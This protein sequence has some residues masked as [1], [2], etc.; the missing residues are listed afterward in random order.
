MYAY[1]IARRSED[2]GLLRPGT[3]VSME[4]KGFDMVDGRCPDEVC[5]ILG[6]VGG[7]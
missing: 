1:F 7:E 3:L 2:V 5:Y 4:D 6:I